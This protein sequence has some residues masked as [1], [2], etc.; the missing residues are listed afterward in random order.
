MKKKI[1]S[2]FIALSL[3]LN[4]M[5]FLQINVYAADEPTV[6]EE[7]YGNEK[8][9]KYQQTS[10]EKSNEEKIAD[11]IKA[12]R[13]YYLNR[14]K[15][16]TY[17]VAL[18]YIFT[19]ENPE[20]DLHTIQQRFKVN[21]NPASASEYVGS[22]M[23][24]LAAGKDPRNYKGRDFVKGLVG[25][26]NADGKFIISQWDDYSTT[27]AFCILALDMVKADYNVE[28]AVMALLNYQGVDGS[29]GYTVDDTA[30]CI[31]ALGNHRNLDGAEEAIKKGLAN[32]KANQLPS[33]GFEAFGSESVCSISAV[34]Q[35][36]IAL[37]EDPL[38]GDWVKNGNTI[39]DALL[40]HMEDDHFPTEFDTEQAFCALADL[41]RGKSMFHEIALKDAEPHRVKIQ[42]PSST[43]IKEGG[44]LKLAANVYNSNG[45]ILLGHNLIWESSDENV[46][47]VSSDGL[48]SAVNSGT[49]TI[50]VKVEKYQDISD[51][52]VMTV[53]PEEF[54]VRRVDSME[55]KNGSEAKL[56]FELEENLGDSKTA[57]LIV[58]LYD[59][60]TNKMIN[61]AFATK[62]FGPK[63]TA[64]L[65]A[66]FLVPD[67]GKYIIR[68]FVWENFESQDVILANPLEIKVNSK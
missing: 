36:L 41:Y 13:N 4:Y 39:L 11:A 29:F 16:F 46:A 1:V 8:D 66:G 65:G 14:D 17:R 7:V 58:A 10:E 64:R 45:E 20:Q 24:L 35:S 28:K 60:N 61:Y 53:V 32:L 26:Q 63:E 49:V 56:E 48:V 21:E 43:T 67:S 3:L 27:V 55:I 25:S 12:L 44:K 62:E 22:I 68:C 47:T 40:S 34:I 51:S 54:K 33:G 50:S 38:S 57:T 59:E 9:E 2:I 15:D 37:G 31:M 23:G 18:S 6:L 30:M 19:S 52:I 5:P 42:M